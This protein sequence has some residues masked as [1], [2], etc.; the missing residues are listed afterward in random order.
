[1]RLELKYYKYCKIITFSFK[2]A[3]TNKA[4]WQRNYSELLYSATL[5][6]KLL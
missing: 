5:L 1:M 6:N 2:I 4:Y 3:F